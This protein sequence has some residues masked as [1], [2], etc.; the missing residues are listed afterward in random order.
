MRAEAMKSLNM[1]CT[2]E[3]PHTLDLCRLLAQQRR[4]AMQIGVWS[5]RQQYVLVNRLRSLSQQR[6]GML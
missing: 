4:M 2:E 1:N 6:R 5:V 3:N